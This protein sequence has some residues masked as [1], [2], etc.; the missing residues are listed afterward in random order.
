MA[1]NGH[2]NG[3]KC[4]DCKLYPDER[5]IKDNNVK[6]SFWPMVNKSSM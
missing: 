1:K 5:A 2:I 4:G 3:N 6:C